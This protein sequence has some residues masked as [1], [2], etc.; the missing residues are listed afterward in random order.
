[1]PQV[2]AEDANKE[3]KRKKVQLY[4]PLAKMLN[5]N[6]ETDGLSAGI[7]HKSVCNGKGM[8][9]NGTFVREVIK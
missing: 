3:H 9:A 1:M 4:A 7:F 5:G 8:T 6:K 2:V